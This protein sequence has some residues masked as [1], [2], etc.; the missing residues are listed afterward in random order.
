MPTEVDV[1]SNTAPNDVAALERQE[2]EALG[3][4]QVGEPGVD[5]LAVLSPFERF[6]FRLCTR[7]NQGRWKRFWTWCQRVFGAGW[8]HLSTYNLMKVY[9]LENVEAVSHDRPILFVAN[10]RSF[11]DMYVVSTT[12]FRRRPVAKTT[13]LSRARPFLLSIAARS[14]SSIW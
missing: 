11:F 12:L 13:L 9:G 5:E 8:I 7:M 4:D 6:A 1:K 3:V 14:C 2:I 10:H